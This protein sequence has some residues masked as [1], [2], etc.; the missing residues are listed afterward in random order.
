MHVL[1]RYHSLLKERGKKKPYYI[2]NCLGESEEAV[3][4]FYIQASLERRKVCSLRRAKR[5]LGEQSLLKE[6]QSVT[7]SQPL[8]PNFA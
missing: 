1:T 2:L 8:T 4:L 7:R 6:M 3:F 5:Y